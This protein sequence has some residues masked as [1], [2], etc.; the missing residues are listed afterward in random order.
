MRKALL[1]M[2]VLVSFV[3][4]VF[5]LGIGGAAATAPATASGTATYYYDVNPVAVPVGPD[6]VVPLAV[7]LCSTTSTAVPTH[8]VIYCYSPSFI[9]AAYNLNSL[10]AAGHDGTGQTIVIVD[11]YGSPTIAS[12]LMHFDSVFGLPDPNFQVICPIGCSA[13]NPRNTAH[14]ELGWAEETTLDV[15]WSHAIAPGANIVLAVAPSNAGNALNAVESYV[16]ANYPGSIISQS[17]GIPEAAVHGNAGQFAQADFNYHLAQAADITVLASSGDFGATNGLASFQNPGFPASDPL[18]LGIGG[19][20]GSPL[21]NLATYDGSSSGC[22]AGPRPGYPTACV[23]T[24]YGAEAAWNEAWDGVAGGGAQSLFFGLPSYQQGV[25]VGGTALT[26]RGVPDVAYNA[27]VDGGVLAYFTAVTV[28]STGWVV[29]GGT[30]AGSPQW[31]GLFAIVNQVR[32]ANGKGPIGFANP[33]IYGL[34]ENPTTYAN[35]FHDITVGNNQLVGTTS[36]NAAVAGY[37]LAT[38]WGTPNG[39][40]LVADLSS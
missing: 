13:F 36:G 26:S 30:S 1:T 14:D 28:N 8:P 9:Y 21:G 4:S 20:Q 25:T 5:A 23:P 17:F 19:T 35:D 22:T 27:A 34:A 31:A 12:D 32:H 33:A 7:P 11:A 2:G 10:Y 40:N 15:E 38:G 16:I 39:A 37:D 3:V 24:G 6:T 29:F 18:V